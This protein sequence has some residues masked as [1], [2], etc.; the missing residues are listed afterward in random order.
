[1]HFSLFG[2]PVRIHPF[3]WLV[4]VLLIAHQIFDAQDLRTALLIFLPWILA[5]FLSILV[6]E[7]G[8]ALMM[9]AY[10][11]S[12]WITL[13]GL[14]GLASYNPGQSY[15]SRSTGTWGQVLISLAGPGAGFVLAAVVVAAV[16][17]TGH[18]VYFGFLGRFLPFVAIP[19]GEVVGSEVF[20]NLLRYILFI[21][22]FWGFLNLMPVYPLD[23]GQIAR[24]LLLRASPQD[25]IRQ[26]LILSVITG[27]GLAVAAFAVL[28]DIL[29]TLF[30]AYLAY[31]SYTTLQ[32]HSGRGG[33]R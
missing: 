31:M 21:S 23:G 32:R 15:G 8:H 16:R 11:F 26:S 3:F 19:A 29:P 22:I 18:D 9:R 30:F 1:L 4:G 6:H 28:R 14:G 33:W 27:V 2:I 7:L 5:L 17:L 13:Y 24:E 10:G 12:P 20:T 25:G